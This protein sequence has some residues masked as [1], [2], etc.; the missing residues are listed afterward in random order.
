MTNTRCSH[1]SLTHWDVVGQHD[2]HFGDGDVERVG[3]AQGDLANDVAADEAG[4]GSHFEAAAALGHKL[5]GLTDST[6]CKE[7]EQPAL[8]TEAMRAFLIIASGIAH[9]MCDQAS[10]HPDMRSATTHDNNKLTSC[11]GQERHHQ[12]YLVLR[13]H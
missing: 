3:V 1:A 10:Q 13:S 4:C 9:G 11:A 2:L 6:C 8:E 7:G 5:D 12:A